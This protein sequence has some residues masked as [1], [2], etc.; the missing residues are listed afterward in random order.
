MYSGLSS[1]GPGSESRPEHHAFC[2]C[3]LQK[4]TVKN[5]YWAQLR[6]NLSIKEGSISSELFFLF[7]LFQH[8]ARQACQ[9]DYAERQRCY[10]YLVR[11]FYVGKEK[12]KHGHQHQR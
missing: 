10:T 4:F 5:R 2:A 9:E 8:L 1:R 6:F 12:C 7:F 11:K 3:I